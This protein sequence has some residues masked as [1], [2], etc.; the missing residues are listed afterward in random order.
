M[1]RGGWLATSFVSIK[2]SY[3]EVTSRDVLNRFYVVEDYYL[4]EKIKKY[5]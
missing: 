5:N 4:R 1:V 2:R 3:L